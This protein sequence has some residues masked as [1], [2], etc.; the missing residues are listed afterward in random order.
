MQRHQGTK[1]SGDAESS[2]GADSSGQ[3]LTLYHLDAYRLADEDE[4]LEL[5]VDELFEQSG[6]WTIIEW[7]DRVADVMPKQTVWVRIEIDVDPSTRS[8]TFF[9]RDP[10]IA[11]ELD[12]VRKATE[13]RVGSSGSTEAR[14]VVFVAKRST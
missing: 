13:S 4:F 14:Q 12:C 8:L 7:A 5:G 1:P 6:A 11:I 10:A 9:C 3:P 2:R